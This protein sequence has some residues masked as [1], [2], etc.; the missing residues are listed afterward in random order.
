M[1][2]GRICQVQLYHD[3]NFSRP[4]IFSVKYFLTGYVKTKSYC[5]QVLSRSTAARP[6]LASSNN[7]LT[8]YYSG[9]PL[10][11][12]ESIILPQASRSKHDQQT[13]NW[14]CAEEE[15]GGKSTCV[16]RPASRSKSS[17]P[18][19]VDVGTSTD[20][21]VVTMTVEEFNQVLVWLFVLFGQPC[22]SVPYFTLPSK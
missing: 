3:Q 5:D 14:D 21:G 11:I 1:F 19:K 9:Q 15:L 12:I 8:Q 2:F 17:C 16:C 20:Q 6:T 10:I 7:F 18:R 22:A 4:N 13:N